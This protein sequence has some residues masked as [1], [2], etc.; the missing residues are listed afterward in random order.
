MERGGADSAGG[1][2]DHVLP[3]LLLEGK[4][5]S[6]IR[7]WASDR[8]APGIQKLYILMQFYRAPF[9]KRNFTVKMKIVAGDK[10]FSILI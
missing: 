8:A 6:G 7:A 1:K 5:A 10:N 9:F 4:L 3:E 2:V